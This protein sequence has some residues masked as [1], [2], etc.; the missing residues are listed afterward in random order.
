MIG[1]LIIPTKDNIAAYLSPLVLFSNE[2]DNI[3]IPK[4]KNNKTNSEV[5]LASQTHQVPQ[6]GFPQI[7]PVIR[8]RKASDA[9]M[10]A[11]LFA[12]QS[13]SFMFQIKKTALEVAIIK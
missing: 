13:A 11:M 8:T 1:K 4:Y 2:L 7:A 12:A 9:P 5:S 6:V 3:I 10:G